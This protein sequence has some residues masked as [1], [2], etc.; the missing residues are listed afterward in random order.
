MKKVNEKE[1]FDYFMKVI[2]NPIGV[3]ALMGNLQCESALYSLSLIH[4]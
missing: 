4:I 1:M 2:K 3:C